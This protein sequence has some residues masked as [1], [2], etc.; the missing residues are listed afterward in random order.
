MPDVLEVPENGC[1]FR[2]PLQGGQK[3][4]WFYDQ[5]R[6]RREAARYAAGADVLDIFCYAGGFG[7]TAA[8]AGARSVTFLDASPQALALA[9]ENAA[10]NAPE[11]ARAKAI[12]GLCGDAFER[13]AELDAQGRRFSLICLDP[14]AFIKRRKD[15]AQ[16]L[17]AYRKINALAMQLLTP[18]GVFV[19]CSCSHHLPAESLRSCVQ[20]AAARRKWQARILYAGGQGA[21]HPVHAAMPET[22]YLKC[23]I[24]HLLP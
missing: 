20:Q 24:A 8:A 19:S 21:D 23:F 12:E 4:G 17:A 11:L 22:A 3:T 15:F 16:G 18:G 6:N 1:I 5:R 14:P 9:T 7:G 13:L 2:A 10:R